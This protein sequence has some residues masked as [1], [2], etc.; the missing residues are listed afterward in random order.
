MVRQNKNRFY[1]LRLPVLI[2][3]AL[4]FLLTF[5][6]GGWRY[7]S[8][9]LALSDAEQIRQRLQLNLQ[10]LES[11]YVRFRTKLLPGS[12]E[13]IYNVELWKSGDQLYRMEMT[14]E[15]EEGRAEVQVVVF[16]GT[17]TYF[18]NHELEEFYPVHELEGG[19]LPYLVLEDYWRSLAEAPQISR[20]AEERGSRHSYYVVEVIPADPHRD[21][22]R[23]IVWLESDTMLPVRIELYDL[24]NRLTQVT[25]FELV[26]LNPA[27]EVN[28]FHVQPALK[29]QS[30]D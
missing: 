26:Q 19:R 22:V 29:P 3:G 20:M 21:R 12:E 10:A 14:R 30:S 16:D 23:E 24:H 8:D 11:Y 18:Y 2:I 15:V 27:L 7:Y 25:V 1:V 5:A 28:L 9:R 17:Q 4:A 6:F 13:I